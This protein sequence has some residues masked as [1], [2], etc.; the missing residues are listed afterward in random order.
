MYVYFK[1]SVLLSH[2]TG[3]ILSLDF[4][5][6]E[7]ILQTRVYIYTSIIKMFYE[8]RIKNTRRSKNM[9]ARNILLQ[10]CDPF[11]FNL[12]GGKR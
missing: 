1:K 6:L 7:K 4:K 8:V 10:S 3:H 11:W 9:R 12:L 5:S 2:I